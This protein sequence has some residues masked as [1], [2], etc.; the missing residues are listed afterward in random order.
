M[1]DLVQTIHLFIRV[2][3]PIHRILCLN[4]AISRSLGT[5]VSARSVFPPSPP[6]P[7]SAAM[8]PK[9][10]AAAP[11]E[12]ETK[13]EPAAK[14]GKKT[15]TEPAKVKEEKV[16]VKDE[17]VEESKPVPAPAKGGIEVVL[18]RW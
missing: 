1:I 7:S 16:K 9:R 13:A 6:N 5:G 14:R 15:K 17:E 4:D 3:G 18:E 11:A 10:K 12:V 8:A 2:L